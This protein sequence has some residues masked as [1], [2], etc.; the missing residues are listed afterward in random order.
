MALV[1]ARIRDFQAARDFLGG[2]PARKVA[3]NTRIESAG[4]SV[5]VRFHDTVVVS[6]SPDVTVLT[7]GGFRTV[8]TKDRLNSFVPDSFRVWSEK[9]V[10][11]LYHYPDGQ[12]HVFAEGIGIRR[13]GTVVNAGDDSDVKG[14][15]K[16]RRRIDRYA[17]AYV[18]DLLAGKIGKPGPGDCLYC[19]MEWTDQAGH[20]VEPSSGHLEA[21][22]DES[23]F[24]PS[25]L[26]RA[27]RQFPASIAAR[28]YIAEA[29]AA[30]EAG[31]AL[32]SGAW[33]GILGKQ[34]AS[35]LRKYMRAQLGL[36]R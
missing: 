21:H 6:Y 18:R 4:D 1:K 10:W 26:V 34:I 15:G 14:A 2:K 25:L 35:S 20:S 36:A 22:M 7:T 30:H 19:Q 8:T 33:A 31:T 5:N 13:D 11:Y 12:R 24:V 27:I 23:Y 17:E 16:L 3:H 9:G 28:G 29:W 32:E